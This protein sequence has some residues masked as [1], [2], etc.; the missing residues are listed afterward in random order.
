M[1]IVQRLVGPLRLLLGVAFVVLLAAQLRALPALYDEWVRA[2]PASAAPAWFLTVAVLVLLSA[3]VVVVCI[4][5]LLAMV[6]SG[7]IFTDGSFVWVDTILGAIAGA[8]VLLLA[9]FLYAA[10]PGRAPGATAAVL[11]LLVFVAAGIAGLLMLVMRAL[12]R[13]ATSL[14]TELEAVV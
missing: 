9:T 14:S 2:S 10:A 8:C 3:Q 11:L 6:R 12:L 7:H 13:Q 1:T 5:K 4:W